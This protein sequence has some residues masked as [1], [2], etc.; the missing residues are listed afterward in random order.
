[1]ADLD[2]VEPAA[3]HR[4]RVV[5]R[6]IGGD[7]LGRWPSSYSFAATPLCVGVRASKAAPVVRAGRIAIAQ[8]TD[9]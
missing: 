5:A 4:R 8:I 6:L 1:V 3:E 7:G 9:R 2:Q